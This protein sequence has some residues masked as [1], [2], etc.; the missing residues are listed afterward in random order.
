MITLA[1]VKQYLSSQGI[2][3]VPDFILE[4]WIGELGAIKDCL[5]GYSVSTALLIQAYLIALFA[6]A[7]G[8]KYISSQSAPSG[9]S[10]S[11]RY[12]SF[13]DRW[14]GQLA[15]LRKADKNGCTSD[16]IPANPN[17]ANGGIWLARGGCK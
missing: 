17:S 5:D 7:Q 8:D 1:Q 2:D 15:L 3:N 12:Q 16:L 10:R 14:N 9:A 11:F 4:A 13:S 6:L